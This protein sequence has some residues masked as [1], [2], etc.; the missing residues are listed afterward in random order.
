MVL[1]FNWRLTGS[2]CPLTAFTLWWLK[3]YVSI[4]TKHPTSLFPDLCLG[5]F[6]S[7][8]LLSSSPG[9]FSTEVIGSRISAMVSARWVTR[10]SWSEWRSRRRRMMCLIRRW[11]TFSSNSMSSISFWNTFLSSETPKYMLYT[12][13]WFASRHISFI[14]TSWLYKNLLKPLYQKQINSNFQYKYITAVR[15]IIL[16]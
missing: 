16:T 7:F 12:C 6:K 11:L 5:T 13:S 14:M 1:R 3:L 2:H 10:G 15:S 8:C 9:R 4:Q